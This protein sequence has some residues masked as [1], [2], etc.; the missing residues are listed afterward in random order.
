MHS[1]PN[2]YPTLFAHM[3]LQVSHFGKF[4][5]HIVAMND[6]EQFKQQELSNILW[7]YATAGESHPQLFSKVSDHIVGIKDLSVFLPPHS[8]TSAGCY[9]M[10]YCRL[11]TP[12]SYLLES[13]LGFSELGSMKRD[14][15]LFVCTTEKFLTH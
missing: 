2:H 14:G 9:C 8:P 12:P 10:L 4:T 11:G 15:G 13:S 1:V 6:L 7:A 3:Q 5:D